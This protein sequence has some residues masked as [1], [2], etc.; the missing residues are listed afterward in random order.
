MEHSDEIPDLYSWKEYKINYSEMSNL[1]I[2]KPMEKPL[3]SEFINQKVYIS[4]ASTSFRL[5]SVHQVLA[6]IFEGFWW[7]DHLYLFLSSEAFLLDAGVNE[8]DISHALKVMVMTYPMTIVFT[9]KSLLYWNC[10]AL[11]MRLMYARNVLIVV[12]HQS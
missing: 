1:S 5:H 9:R 7:P 3:A 10:C 12:S 8:S 6:N 11:L 2:V 4:M